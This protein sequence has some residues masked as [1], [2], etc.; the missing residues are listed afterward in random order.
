MK[1][2]SGSTH[3]VSLREVLAKPPFLSGTSIEDIHF[4][5]GYTIL[6]ARN[7]LTP[8]RFRT[9][10]YFQDNAPVQ[11]GSSCAVGQVANLRP[12]VNRPSAVL[13]SKSRLATGC[14]LTTCPTITLPHYPNR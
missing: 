11:R 1:I 10:W 2:T 14:R 13:R 4:S 3:Q 6:N 7:G 12:I 9:G 8:A 5:S